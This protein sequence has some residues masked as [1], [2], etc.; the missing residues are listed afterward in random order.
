MRTIPFGSKVAVWSVLVTLGLPV[1]RKTPCRLLT[2]ACVHPMGLVAP[3]L[4]NVPADALVVLPPAVPADALVVLPPA[5]PPTL[6]PRTYGTPPLPL[7]P[8]SGARVQAAND[9][10]TAIAS[11][12]RW[13]F[14][15]DRLSDHT[16]PSHSPPSVVTSTPANPGKVRNAQDHLDAWFA[17]DTV[18]H[19]L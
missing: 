11:H 16:S 15:H 12:P 6:P 9:A 17:I 3:P 5:A 1:G 4:L 10:A 7:L 18:S 14:M 8:S 2:V 13:C 19:R